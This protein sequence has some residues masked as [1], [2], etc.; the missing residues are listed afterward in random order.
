[1]TLMVLKSKGHLCCSGGGGLVTKSCPT[2]T[3]PW[4]VACQAPS[5]SGISQ[6]RMLE[7]IVISS[8][9]VSSQSRNRTCISCLADRFFTATPPGSP[10]CCKLSLN[11]SLSDLS[12]WFSSGLHFGQDYHWNG[13]LNGMWHLFVHINSFKNYILITA[14]LSYNSHIIKSTILKCKIQWI[15]VY[16]QS[17][18]VIITI[19]FKTF[20]HPRKTPSPLLIILHALFPGPSNH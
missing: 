3:T 7:W 16:S 4:T 2:L 10:L 8:S 11:L 13:I 9:R 15:L 17:C 14:L 19:N 20:H 6:P 18:T 1:M 5:V 12:S